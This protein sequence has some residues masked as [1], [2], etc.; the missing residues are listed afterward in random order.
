MKPFA[1]LRTFSLALATL[2]VV[3]AALASGIYSIIYHK[4]ASTG[5]WV[6]EPRERGGTFLR[7]L[8]DDRIIVVGVYQHSLGV[9]PGLEKIEVKINEK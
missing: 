8:G 9:V 3:A 2:L 1:S 6:Y 4:P 5:L 7:S